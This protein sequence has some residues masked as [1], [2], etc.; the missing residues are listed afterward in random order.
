MRG[1]WP[2][3]GLYVN[4]GRR[5]TRLGNDGIHPFVDVPH[6]ACCTVVRELRRHRVGFELRPAF[7]RRTGSED[8]DDMLDRLVFP[9]ADPTTIQGLLDLAVRK[10]LPRP[11]WP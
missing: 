7:I 5:P 11:L 6:W 3:T 4:P 8:P 10:I 2:C 9:T 1:W